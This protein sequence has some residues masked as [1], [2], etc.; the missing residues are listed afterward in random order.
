MPSTTV[1]RGYPYPVPADTTDIPGDIQRLAEAVDSDLCEV[2][3]AIPV[4]PALRIRGTDAVEVFTHPADPFPGAA[5]HYDIED[6]RT[7]GITYTLSHS[8][9]GTGPTAVLRINEPGAFHV[10]ASLAVPRPTDGVNRIEM[11]VF[12]RTGQSGAGPVVSSRSVHLQ[13]SASDGIRTMTVSTLIRSSGSGVSGEGYV[14]FWFL[15]RRS[16]VFSD[17][18]YTVGERSLTVVRMSPTP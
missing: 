8:I 14:S 12:L 13:P 18:T 9:S 4:R 16:N 17:D 10:T 11:R 2:T 15:S 1:N 3:Q 5:V 6:F 7:P